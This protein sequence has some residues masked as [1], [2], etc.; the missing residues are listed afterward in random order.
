MPSG[1]CDI[2]ETVKLK[3][4]DHLDDPAVGLR[5]REAGQLLSNLFR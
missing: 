4:G 5:R 3:E 1:V 2:L